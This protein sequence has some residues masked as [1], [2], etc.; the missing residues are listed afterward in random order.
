MTMILFFLTKLIVVSK[1]SL[2][3]VDCLQRQNDLDNGSA[4]CGEDWETVVLEV[5]GHVNHLKETQDGENTSASG[6]EAPGAPVEKDA[7]I[8]GQVQVRLDDVML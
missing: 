7:V 6:R 3:T 2:W 8:L 4:E 1:D 5:V